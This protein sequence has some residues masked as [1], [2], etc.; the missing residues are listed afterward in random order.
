MCVNYLQYMYVQAVA[1]SGKNKP[2]EKEKDKK[3][4][5]KRERGNLTYS[6]YCSIIIVC[7]CTYVLYV[8]VC[9]GCFNRLT[10]EASQ[11]SPD[12]FRVRQL[13]QCAVDAIRAIEQL[14]DSLDDPEGDP[15]NFNAALKD[16][17]VRTYMYVLHI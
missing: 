11:P 1:V 14:I 2:A 15:H 7:M 13:K 9:D 17:E 10:H 6:C 16:T 5:D 8:V 4:D 3:K 12:H